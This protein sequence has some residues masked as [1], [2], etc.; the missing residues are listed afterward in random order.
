MKKKGFIIALLAMA[1]LA[2]GCGRQN[3]LTDITGNGTEKT[4]E[5]E[6]TT[7]D[8]KASEKHISD[9]VLYAGICSELGYDADTVLT[10]EDYESVTYLAIWDGG[11]DSLEGISLLVNLKELHIG[12]GSIDDISELAAIK[13]I[14][15]IDISHNLIEQIPDFSGCNELDRLYFGCNR[16]SDISPLTRA[17]SVEYADFNDNFIKT[18]QPLKDYTSIGSIVLTGNCIMD[19]SSVLTNTELVSAIEEGSAIRISDCIAVEQRAE[20]IADGIMSLDAADRE[21]YIYRFVIDN[22]EYEVRDSSGEPYAYSGLIKGSGVC[23]DYAEMF[24]MI[25]NKAGIE[26][27]VCSS[28]THAWNVVKTDEGWRHC[29]ALWDDMDSE[30]EYYNIPGD[31]IIKIEDH[32]YDTGRYPW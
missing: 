28:D 6:E 23:V 20:E 16:I 29:D 11:V 4:E 15:V 25:A 26:C 22:M 9:T 7:D 24:C 32:G 19:Y 12:P 18:I 10:E 17:V 1:V 13:G 8:I 14:E 30:W 5:T 2:N 31:V 3:D 27:Y 21:E